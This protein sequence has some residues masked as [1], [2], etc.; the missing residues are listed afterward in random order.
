MVKVELDSTARFAV[1]EQEKSDSTTGSESRFHREV[2]GKKL[3]SIYEISICLSHKSYS[4]CSDLKKEVQAALSLNSDLC[5][6]TFELGKKKRR[7]DC[8]WY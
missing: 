7:I 5:Q 2:A 1:R 3:S 4:D 8:W 6:A